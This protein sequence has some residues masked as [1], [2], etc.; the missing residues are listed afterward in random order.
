ML[1]GIFW[2]NKVFG[3]HP[4]KINLSSKIVYGDLLQEYADKRDIPVEL[5]I[6]IQIRETGFMQKYD[7]TTAV[8]PAGAIGIMQVMSYHTTNFGLPKRALFDPETNIM[9][10]SAIVKDNFVLY[11]GNIEKTLAAYNGGTKQANLLQTQRCKETRHYVSNAMK[12]I[13]YLQANTWVCE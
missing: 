6:A 9:I 13:R 4:V 2:V 7:R 1:I 3:S 10:S 11:K 8:S 12:T 5:L